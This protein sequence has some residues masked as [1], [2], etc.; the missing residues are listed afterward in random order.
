MKKPWINLDDYA[1]TQ[2]RVET[3]ISKWDLKII[4]KIFD[5]N[6]KAYEM[7]YRKGPIGRGSKDY[8]EFCI[9]VSKYAQ[10]E[11]DRMVSDMKNHP[12]YIA[13]RRK[14]ATEIQKNIEE[15]KKRETI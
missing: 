9:I 7:E 5:Q 13:D 8:P 14:T 10:A 15:R 1:K 2:D 6:D 3:V 4:K 12:E 11:I